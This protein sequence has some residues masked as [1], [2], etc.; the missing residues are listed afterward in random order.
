MA[1][2]VLGIVARLILKKGFKKAVK[3]TR[4]YRFTNLYWRLYNVAD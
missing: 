2:P 3:K 1:L 4:V